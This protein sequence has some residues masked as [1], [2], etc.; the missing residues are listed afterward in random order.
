M[1]EPTD[2]F[3][4]GTVKDG[5]ASLV[6]AEDIGEPSVLKTVPQ[7]TIEPNKLEFAILSGIELPEG[8][9]FIWD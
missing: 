7:L 4:F 5:V 8:W 2:V 1:D 9:K 6:D 3:A